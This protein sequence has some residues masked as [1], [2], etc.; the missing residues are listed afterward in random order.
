MK[1]NIIIYISLVI[2][3]ILNFFV[4]TPMGLGYYNE[5][6]HPLMWI[7]LCALAV[8]L[9]RDSSIRVKGEQDK[10]QSLLIALIAYII[11]YFLLG[12]VFGF[13]RTPYAKDIVSI[14]KNLWSFAG[15]IFSKNL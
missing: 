10:T 7:F 1:Q 3:M 4:I 15:L 5:I 9:S 11:V 6:I 13:E 14:I 8:F 2:Y 12:L